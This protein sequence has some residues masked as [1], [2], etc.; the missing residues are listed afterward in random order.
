MIVS[1]ELGG[2]WNAVK[3]NVYGSVQELFRSIQIKPCK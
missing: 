3:A 2:M 1:D